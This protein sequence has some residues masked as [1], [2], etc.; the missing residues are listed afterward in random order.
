M[1]LISTNRCFLVGDLGVNHNG[2]VSIAKELIKECYEAGFDAVKFQK[3]TIDIVY[4]SEEL[5]MPRESPWGTTNREQ[6]IGLE[7]TF[8][9]YEKIDE[10]CKSLGILWTASPWDIPSVDFLMQFDI[11]YIKIASASVTDKALLRYCIN[12]GKPLWISTGM[13]GMALIMKIV[14]WIKDEGGS[15]DLLYHC[16]STYP[17]NIAHL[18]LTAIQT[19]KKALQ[20]PI[21]FSGHE[22]GPVTSVMAAVLGAVS[23]ERHVTLRRNMYGS[24]QAA[25]LE[26]PGFRRL[27]RDIRDWEKARGDGIPIVYHVE[28]P[29][30]KKLRRVDDFSS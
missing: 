30:E 24:D 16:T 8:N 5:D 4:T 3:R 9:D 22:P 2:N 28:L 12:T 18:N 1:N 27:V 17:T 23:V 20:L 6:K 11:P 7:L 15:V 10:F 29:I 25:S 21:G 19:L 14:K 26:P 13:C